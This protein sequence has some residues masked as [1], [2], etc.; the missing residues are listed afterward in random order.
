[1]KMD[2][3]RLGPTAKERHRSPNQIL[4][5]LSFC[6]FSSTAWLL[7]SSSFFLK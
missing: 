5:F 7:I 4:R 6:V 3:T 2:Q 1:M